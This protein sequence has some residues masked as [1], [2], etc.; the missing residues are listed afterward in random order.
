MVCR[1]LLLCWCFLVRVDICGVICWCW[2]C[3]VCRFILC[4][5][6]VVLMLLVK[7]MLCLMLLLVIVCG[8]LVKLDVLLWFGDVC[9]VCM[10][11]VFDVKVMCVEFY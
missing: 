2:L 3:N 9:K 7:M 5:L 4:F 1:V 8:N 10:Y 6:F 11:V